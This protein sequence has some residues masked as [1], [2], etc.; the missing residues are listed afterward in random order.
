MHKRLSFA[1][2]E[3]Q[4]PNMVTKVK[5]QSDVF[6]PGV[7][8]EPVQLVDNALVIVADDAKI[9]D[10][11]E[12]IIRKIAAQFESAKKSVDNDTKELVVSLE[13]CLDLTE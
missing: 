8:D 3:E 2:D 13:S 5:Y 10:F 7:G 11:T 12:E 9:K 1:Y 6:I 4:R